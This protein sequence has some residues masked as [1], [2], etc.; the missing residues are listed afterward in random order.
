MNKKL[1]GFQDS[2]NKLVYCKIHTCMGIKIFKYTYGVSSPSSGTTV[3]S[4]MFLP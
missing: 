3:L 1:A 2:N 4:V